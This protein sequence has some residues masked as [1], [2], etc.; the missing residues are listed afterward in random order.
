MNGCLGL[1][2]AIAAA[3]NTKKMEQKQHPTRVIRGNTKCFMA[4]THFTIDVIFHVHR[5][6]NTMA[7]EI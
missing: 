3:Q 4:V 6:E 1:L 7:L 5:Y 2:A